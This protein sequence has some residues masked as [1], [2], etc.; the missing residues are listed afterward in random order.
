MVYAYRSG[1]P[2]KTMVFTTL[3]L[4]QMGHA[5]AARS[6][7]PLVQVPAFSNP[8]LLA[9]VGTTTLLQL[10]LVYV[11]PL[12]SFFGTSP[13]S[14][15]DLAICF[16]VSLLFFVYLELEKVFRLWRRQRHADA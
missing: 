6:D 9:A 8:W 7:R 4:A 12:A 10:L 13:L 11:K 5:L 2:W 15:R 1:A 14:L 3:C 16:G